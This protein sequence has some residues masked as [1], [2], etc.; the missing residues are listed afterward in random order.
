MKKMF[1][2]VVLAVAALTM[3]SPVAFAAG[4][5]EPLP[6]QD[7]SFEGPTGTY[8]RAALQRGYKIYREVCA[9]C[10]GMDLLYYR[11]L[12]ALGYNENQ[13]KNI[14]AEYIY[15]DGPNEEGDMFERPGLPS[16]PFKN[17]YENEKQAAYANNNA[18]PP[19]LSL[20]AKARA[21]GP[22][23]IYALLVG[24][25][26]HAPHGKELLTG[27]YWNKYKDG[28]VIAMAPP[29][30]DGQVQY[31]DGTPQTLDQYSRDIAHF[32]MWAADPYMETRKQTGIKVILF[33]LVFAGIMYALKKKTWKD[34]H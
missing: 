10:H 25:E 14:A 29:L 8:D 24:Y 18:I 20:M 11:N 4:G 23:Y 27:Q 33:L 7:W 12:S 28:N 2:K 13:I 34:A 1:R 3:I 5:G 16:D 32:L 26:D 22:D 30:V 21:G 15:E 17:P 9:A 6:D 19:D 31:E